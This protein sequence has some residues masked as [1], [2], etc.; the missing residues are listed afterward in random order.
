MSSQVVLD[1]AKYVVEQV[2]NRRKLKN[3]YEYEASFV[4][5]SPDKNKWLPRR[6]LEDNGFGKLVN[7]VGAREAAAA[8]MHSTPLTAANIAKHL[9]AVG[10]DPEFTLHH[11]MRGL[12]GGQKV[13]VVIGDKVHAIIKIIQILF[14][15]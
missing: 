10:L 3:S 4:G 2:L 9:E 11:R 8:G 6:W 15:G 7:Q 12:S 1:G 14:I 5:M 13:K